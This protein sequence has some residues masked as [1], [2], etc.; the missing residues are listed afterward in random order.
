MKA[1]LYEF[2]KEKEGVR[3]EKKGKEMLKKKDLVNDRNIDKGAS[4]C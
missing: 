3:E 2:W 4:L 1:A